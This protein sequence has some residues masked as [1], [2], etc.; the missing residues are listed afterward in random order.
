PRLSA[1]ASR[2]VAQ[3]LLHWSDTRVPP[4]T[5]SGPTTPRPPLPPPLEGEFPPTA[6]SLAAG[7]TRGAGPAPLVSAPSPY[8]G[9]L[10]RSPSPTTDHGR[11]PHPATGCPPQP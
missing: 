7:N 5:S 1:P 2:A 6:E 10:P 11:T 4:A 3:S 8:S 9:R